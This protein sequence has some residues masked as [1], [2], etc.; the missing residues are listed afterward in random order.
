MKFVSCVN[1]TRRIKTRDRKECSDR[2]RMN[3]KKEES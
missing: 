3:V 2:D 1:V